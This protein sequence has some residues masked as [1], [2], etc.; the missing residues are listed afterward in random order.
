MAVFKKMKFEM[1]FKKEDEWLAV[2]WRKGAMVGNWFSS[3]NI[4]DNSLCNNAMKSDGRK[5]KLTAGKT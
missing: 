2:E 1:S 5:V 3:S 4:V